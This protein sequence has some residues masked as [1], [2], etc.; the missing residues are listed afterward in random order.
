[1]RI[2]WN[3]GDLA[4]ARRVDHGQ[5]TLAVADE[6][7]A[8]RHIGPHV[9]GVVAKLDAASRGEIGACEDVN[10]SVARVRNIDLVRGAHVAD[11]LRLAKSAK[12]AERAHGLEIDHS[13]RVIAELGNEQ[14]L[15]AGIDRE[16]I[17]PA[18]YLAERDL[19]LRG[20][21]DFF[22]TRQSGVPTLRVGDLLRDKYVHAL[23]LMTRGD[24]LRR[25]DRDHAAARN[26][27]GARTGAS[28]GTRNFDQ[29]PYSCAAI[30]GAA[31]D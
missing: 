31:F 14:A 8:G 22:G 18:A 24:A 19:A 13:Y 21:G 3:V 20:P 25:M 29:R 12:R 16:M 28:V 10:R 9:I 11:A 30:A 7:P 26:S 6:Y 17:D 23:G 15:A 27:L 2:E 5:S 4:V 1:M